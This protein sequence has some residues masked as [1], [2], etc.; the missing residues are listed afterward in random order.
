VV[1]QEPFWKSTDYGVLWSRIE[2]DDILNVSTI[3]QAG[4]GAVYV[5]TGVSL[6]PASDK[7]AE[8]STIGKGIY[9]LSGNSFQ[10]M[11]GTAPS[12][13]DVDGEWAFIQKLAVDGSGKLYAAT[14]TGL[15]YYNGASWVFAKAGVDELVG[16]S[17]D[18]AIYD[19]TI[20]AAVAGNTYVSTGGFNGF[21]L[22]SDGEEGMLPT[23]EFG[24]IKFA[25]SQS[26]SNYI[27]A[28]YVNTDGAMYNAYLSTD[29]GESW[30]VIYPG[31]SSM[32]DIFNGKG[33]R[34]N[35]I[36]VDP[37]NEKAVYIGAHNLNFGYEAQA[38][39]YYSWQQIT[40]GN[41]NPYG[42]FGEDSYLHFGVNTIVFNPYKSGQVVFGTDGGIG[43]TKDNFNSMVI[44]N[45]MYNT[46]EYFTINASKSGIVTAGA[47]FN[48]VHKIIDNGSK[49]AY[50]L[51][52]NL[53]LGPSPQTGGYS[54]ISFINPEFY[55]CSDERG[56]FW[57]SEDEGINTEPILGSIKT[58]DEFITPFLMWESPNNPMSR[59]SVEFVARK[60]YHAGDDIWATSRYYDFPFQTTIDIDLDSAQSTMIIDLV[61]SKCF[62]AVEG[63][64]KAGFDGGVYMTTG[65]LDYTADPSWWQI[66]AVEGIPTCMAYSKDAN[67]L[68]VGTLEGRLFRLS[69]IARAYDKAT[70]DITSPGC[71][72]AK[73]EITLN[74]TQAITSLTVD[75]KD[76]ENVIFTL[77]NYGNSDYVFASFD[78]MSDNP[79]F[80][81][82]Q[83][84]LP[85]MPLYA[86]TFEVNKEG[87]VFVGTENGLF[88]TNQFDDG[89]VTWVYEDA[90]RSNI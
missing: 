37:T 68:W 35:S 58:G 88:Y 14:N 76:S 46:T 65:M 27:Y 77:G 73:T 51:L 48:G 24:N 2:M 1:Q 75:P 78:G 17:C 56:V 70:A 7:L 4:D 31:G 82:I 79:T 90:K 84:N 80:Q 49:Q 18:I 39:G 72:I 55:V 89:S 19:G 15:K 52:G 59:D 87:L 11:E 53:F 50:E 81:S 42:G 5:G 62:I 60:D 23:G 33:L 43:A 9:K 86:S 13:D 25:I 38:T 71:I 16:K 12:A 29:K 83:G 3:C 57:R 45:R 54:H 28:S 74:T 8:G 66:G 6:E 34:N 64:S 63:S 21:V 20:I 32:G 67:Y 40:D 85:L 10:L 61:A 26:N 22:K 36:A 47:Q 30:R 41:A 69:N 44:L